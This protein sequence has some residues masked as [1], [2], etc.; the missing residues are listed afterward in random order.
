MP[1]QISKTYVSVV[2][3]NYTVCAFEFAEKSLEMNGADSVGEKKESI[4]R[5]TNTLVVLMCSRD[6]LTARKK[7]AL[8]K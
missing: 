7:K 3:V 2:A 8:L 1:Y 4:D 6:V 5:W